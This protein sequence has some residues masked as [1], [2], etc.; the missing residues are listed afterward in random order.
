MGGGHI[1]GF[2]QIFRLKGLIAMFS[3][4]HSKIR[5]LIK[6]QIQVYAFYNSHP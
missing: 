3:A 1:F 2:D 6:A 5:N 4:E